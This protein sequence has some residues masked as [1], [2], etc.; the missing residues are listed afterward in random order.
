MCVDYRDLN[1]ACPKD[2][3]P[4][5][6]IDLLVDRMAGHEMVSLTDL[7]VGVMPFGLQKCR[8]TLPKNGTDNLPRMIHKEVDQLSQGLEI[9][10]S[11]AK[12]IL[13]NA[14]TTDREGSTRFLGRLQYISRFTNPDWLIL[15]G[16]IFQTTP[17]KG[18][19]VNV[20]E[21]LSESF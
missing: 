4:L 3:F 15:C 19:A 9:D 2:D 10:P 20:N 14:S 18:V 12:A 7:A 13:G 17:A 21:D 8:G 16:P 11:K 6:H 5:P 1:K